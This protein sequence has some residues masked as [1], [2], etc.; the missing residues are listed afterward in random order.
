MLLNIKE[1][2]VQ[3]TE[4]VSVTPQTKYERKDGTDHQTR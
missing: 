4:K 2:M 1:R 3:T